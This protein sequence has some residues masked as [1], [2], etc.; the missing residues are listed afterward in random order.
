MIHQINELLTNW[1]RKLKNIWMNESMRKW[2]INKEQLRFK[3]IYEKQINEEINEI[4]KG[5]KNKWINEKQNTSKNI[6]WLNKSMNKWINI[7]MSK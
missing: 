3:W 1:I 2:K 6:K 4:K 7:K 5:I